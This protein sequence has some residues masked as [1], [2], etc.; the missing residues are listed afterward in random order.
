MNALV[1]A[2]VMLIVFNIRCAV[3]DIEDE[4]GHFSLIPTAQ[5]A[6]FLAALHD[7]GGERCPAGFASLSPAAVAAACCQ[8][9][10]SSNTTQRTTHFRFRQRYRTFS[11][12]RNRR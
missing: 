8:Q 10:S 1:L 11:A 4:F 6:L 5:A 12:K 2:P 3:Y 7:C 9:P